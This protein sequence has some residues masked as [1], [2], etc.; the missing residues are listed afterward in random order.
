MAV[1]FLTAICYT[2]YIT[3]MYKKIGNLYKNYSSPTY[4][5]ISSNLYC[6]AAINIFLYIHLLRRTM[7]NYRREYRVKAQ[8]Q[9]NTF[10][11]QRMQFVFFTCKVKR[12]QPSFFFQ[13]HK[14][15]ADIIFCIFSKILRLFCYRLFEKSSYS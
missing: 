13:H 12:N 10:K 7:P 4:S 1:R 15:K 14:A 2:G 8:Q 6:N 3:F 5:A 11:G 9:Y